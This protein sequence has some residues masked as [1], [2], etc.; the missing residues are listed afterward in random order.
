LSGLG[1]VS[2]FL[3]FSPFDPQSVASAAGFDGLEIRLS[4]TT[5]VVSVAEP[6]VMWDRMQGRARTAIRK[7]HRHGL[8]ALVRPATDEDVVAGSD[9]RSLYEDT[10]LRVDA[11]A[12]YSFDEDYYG[13]LL[14]AL[15][16]DLRVVEVRDGDAVV[17][18]ALVMH[19]GDRVHYHLSGSDPEG[20]RN[21]ANVLLVWSMLEWCAASGVTWC[22]LGGGR[23]AQRDGLARFKRS[24]GGEESAFHVGRAILDQESYARLTQERAER[25]GT[26]T[27]ALEESGFFPTFRAGGGE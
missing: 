15:G 13:G 25:L 9:F 18:S 5:F 14:Q 24:F 16:A 19:H 7:A 1:V 3:R 8:T 21:G 6:D 12:R 11:P 27:V 23:A 17:A 20:S 4:G 2:L 26:T 10:M 22:H